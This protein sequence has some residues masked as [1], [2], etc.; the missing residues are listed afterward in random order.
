MSATYKIAAGIAAGNTIVLKPSELTPVATI[1]FA[2]LATDAGLPPGALNVVTGDG[3]TGTALTNHEDISKI[4]FTG[5][6]EVGRKVGATAGKNV[7]SVTLELGGKNPNI[8]FP[9]ADLSNAVTDAI[10]GIFAA[11]GQ[12]CVAGSR[13]LIHE[14][15]RDEFVERF[16]EKTEELT[17][18]DPFDEKTQLAPLSSN[19]QFEKV[20]RYVE[21]AQEEGATVLTGGEPADDLPGGLFYPPTVLDGVTNDMR[22][23]QEEVFGPVV[24]I[25]TFET[26]Q[27]A[28]EI[29]NDTEY[30]LAA[31]LWT[32][33]L[34]RA[35]RLIDDL[36]AGVVW[37]N[38]YRKSSF[39][40]P[41]GG[42]KDS[43]VGI[44]KGIDSIEDYLTTKSVW[45]KRE[46]EI[47]DPFTL[48]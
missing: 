21:I 5:G 19:R 25:I 3:E 16:V 43:G 23:A 24:A 41:F 48:M 27:E 4:A 30:G 1:R 18:G 40:T 26:E 20:R 12:T 45:I 31:G 36:E 47:S 42:V 14:S 35:M 37:V 9:D 7:N 32:E 6:L 22:I 17:L 28:V 44:E 39:T 34:G 29:A 33:N 2:E 15:I 13:L 38:T 8:V 10:K 46:G 11:S